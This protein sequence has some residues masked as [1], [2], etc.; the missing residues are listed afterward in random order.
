MVVQPKPSISRTNE[1]PAFGTGFSPTGDLFRTFDGRDTVRVWNPT[2]LTEMAIFRT[3]DE[4]AVRSVTVAWGQRGLA[5]NQ[6]ANNHVAI[7]SRIPFRKLGEVKDSTNTVRCLVFARDPKLLAVARDDWPN[8]LAYTVGVWD[9]AAETEITRLPVRSQWMAEMSFSPDAGLLALGYQDGAVEV[10]HWRNR[11]KLLTIQGASEPANLILFLS[12][13]RRLV[14]GSTESGVI[15]VWDL[16]NQSQM[17]L[18]GQV[19]A[20][21]QIAESRDGRRLAAGGADGTITIWDLESYAEVASLRG[22][23][24]AVLALA[25]LA[26]GNTLTSV[27]RESMRVWRAAPFTETDAPKPA[28]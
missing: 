8:N 22:H 9:W 16:R 25:F 11:Q 21:G 28:R 13:Q 12:D 2:N 24:D 4:S 18:S 3:P 6:L 5:A 23:K 27:S 19:T 10:W 14:V 1:P 17:P 7:Y 20:Y 26:D 15:R